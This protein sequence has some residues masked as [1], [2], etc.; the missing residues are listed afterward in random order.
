M[1]E[2]KEQEANNLIEKSKEEI[3]QMLVDGGKVIKTV[4]QEKDK[5][6]TITKIEP[7][8][9]KSTSSTVIQTEDEITI[10]P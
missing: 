10:N 8:E 5:T 7:V 6:T 9:G 2:I 4:I 3:K 1:E